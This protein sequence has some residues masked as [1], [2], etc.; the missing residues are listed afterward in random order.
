MDTQENYFDILPVE[1]L[2]IIL[3]ETTDWKG[4]VNHVN[5]F[6]R[7]ILYYSNNMKHYQININCIV[8]TSSLIKWAINNKLPLDIKVSISASRQGNLKVLKCLKK[9]GWPFN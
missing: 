9:N 2:L 3:N 6:W 7:S 4:I 5:S 8:Q 1:I